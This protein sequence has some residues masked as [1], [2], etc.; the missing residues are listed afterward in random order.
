MFASPLTTQ[1]QD[2][3]FI[4]NYKIKNEGT[5]AVHMRESLKITHD[6]NQSEIKVMKIVSLYRIIRPVRFL[7]S[8][9]CE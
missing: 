4:L 2:L 5:H 8:L 1:P 3:P 9:Q 7:F 6:R